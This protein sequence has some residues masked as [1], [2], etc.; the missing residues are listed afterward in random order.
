MSSTASPHVLV[1]DDDAD[2][3]EL[4]SF[5]LGSVG[6]RVEAAAD[7]ASAAETVTRATPHVVITDWRLPDG[8]GLMVA[9]ALQEHSASRHVPIIAV[10]GVS[11]SAVLSEEARRRGFVS[12]LLKPASPDDILQAVRYATE[13]GTARELRRAA[14]RL[15]RY[16]KTVAM[17][18]R[19]SSAQTLD[20]TAL[21]TRAA[22]RSGHDI[23]LMLADDSAHYVAAGGSVRDLTGYDTQEL[24]SLSVWDLTPPPDASSG[25]GLWSSFIQSGAQEG[26]YRLRRRD[27]LPV[28]AQYCA[29][30]N[31]VP[32][33]HVSAVAKA[34]DLPA[35][36]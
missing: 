9:A 12:T 8:D 28:D 27:G 34:S 19:A 13:V 11:M 35:S 6:Y 5:L 32:G 31:I 2:T 22:A 23:T 29:I 1:V 3:R 24:L 14:L 4:Y 15:R 16:A 17:R 18:V 33:L 25:Q 26:R 10:T 20:P 21:V 30:A 36:L 7:V